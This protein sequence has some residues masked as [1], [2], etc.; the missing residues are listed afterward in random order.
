MQEHIRPRNHCRWICL[1]WLIGLVIPAATGFAAGLT[2]GPS[3]TVQIGV[4]GISTNLLLDFVTIQ[5]GGTVEIY[6]DVTLTVAG[7]VVIDGRILSL[8]TAKMPKAGP[9]E[10]G[11]DAVSGQH[12]AYNGTLGEHGTNWIISSAPLTIRSQ[13]DVLIDGSILLS[14]KLDGGDGG[15]G[16]RGG[17]GAPGFPLGAQGGAGGDGGLAGLVG[18][19][20]IFARNRLELG[21]G[22]VLSLDN[23][24]VGGAGGRGGDAGDGAAGLNGTGLQNGGAG[25]SGG[26]LGYGGQGASGRSGGFLTLRADVLT[27]RGLIS[28]TGSPGGRG[29]DA[30]LPG[31]GGKGGN[32][33]P[34]L[35][36]P[37][38]PPPKGGDGGNAGNYFGLGNVNIR[39]EGGM[40]GSGGVV[41]LDARVL[42]NEGI[43]D[44]SGGPGGKGGNGWEAGAAP[45]GK[46][47]NPGGKA[48]EDSD[49]FP[50]GEKGAAGPVGIIQVRNPWADVPGSQWVFPSLLS[51]SGGGSFGPGPGGGDGGIYSVTAGPGAS[52]RISAPVNT[53]G[54][55]VQALELVL[56]Y[57]WTTPTG[58]LDVGL[59]GVNLLHQEA[60][61]V[62]PGTFTEVRVWITDPA[63]LNRFSQQLVL[64]LSP[65][66]T[67][68]IELAEFVVLGA[69][70]RLRVEEGTGSPDAVLLSWY[71]LQGR[72]YQLQSAPTAGAPDWLNVSGPVLGKNAW[73]SNA[74][75]LAP[76]VLQRFYR[77]MILAP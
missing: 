37:P 43:I 60:P 25:G 6:G 65:S 48:G 11:L 30:G 71:G 69:T 29:G 74:P 46:G 63:I 1:W 4:P 2:V 35:P 3:Q 17:N 61:V 55:G 36:K 22:S 8:P 38:N 66:P 12:G 18:S 56:R 19:L 13:G 14:S 34:D 24:G 73:I 68:A 57:R 52:F 39:G 15:D 16:G 23:Y 64:E 31:S 47:G 9:G 67:S 70:D 59:A 21:P 54:G 41:T 76:G 28:A 26:P 10:D 50:P 32:A 40:G 77:L 5:A 75:S 20:R 51:T 45:G 44:V 33:G 49:A 58:S 27:L 53:G 7:N 62:V 42:I 72:S